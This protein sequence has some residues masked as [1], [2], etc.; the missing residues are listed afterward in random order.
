VSYDPLATLGGTLA[1]T[2]T[3]GQRPS[4][5]TLGNS[6]S[7]LARADLYQ[8]IS[9]SGT[10]S[11]AFVRT[12]TGR[13]V[14]T[15]S[16]SWSVSVVPNRFVSAS[17]NGA[18]SWSGSTGG[19]QPTLHDQR[20]TV[21]GTLSL[22]PFPALSLTGSIA[23]QFGSSF[24]TTLYA[25]SGAFSP[26]RGGALVFAYAYQETYDTASFTRARSH[27]PSARWNI[28]PRW[29][30]SANYSFQD[31][32]TPAQTMTGRALVANLVIAF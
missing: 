8:G 11:A 23:R 6:V 19:G 24:A 20:G 15:T 13:E 29:Y 4:G 30:L 26:L 7:V 9:A 22:V 25:F 18:Y 28:R 17:T 1:Y 3:Y 16:V 5:A 12:E 32:T 21:E 14:R 31:T 27:G 2:G 10:S